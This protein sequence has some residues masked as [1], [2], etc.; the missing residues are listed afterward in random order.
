MVN[1]KVVLLSLV[2]LG[3]IALTFLVDWLFILGAVLI[4]FYNQK[5]LGRK[6]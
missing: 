4:W 3:F 1:I 6:R 5:E 2:A